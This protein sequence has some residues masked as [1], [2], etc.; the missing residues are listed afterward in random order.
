MIIVFSL[1]ES[2]SKIKYL[3]SVHPLKICLMLLSMVL[4]VFPIRVWHEMVTKDFSTICGLK[5]LFQNPSFLSIWIRKHFF[6]E[7]KSLASDT[8]YFSDL[9]ARS[10][11]ELIFGGIDSSKYT[12]SIT[13]LPV[14]VEEDWEFQ[15][16]R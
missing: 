1:M 15:M 16:D 12:G 4:W 2:Q 9:N 5:V 7:Y 10:G 11:G 6:S 14:V 3:R 13:Y 8:F